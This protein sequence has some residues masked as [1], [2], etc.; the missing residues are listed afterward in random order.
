ML[1]ASLHAD[2]ALRSLLQHAPDQ[3]TVVVGAV[4][5][6]L[7]SALRQAMMD[8]AQSGE[9]AYRSTLLGLR[10]GID[11]VTLLHRLALRE[12]DVALAAWCEE[13]MSLRV[14][15]VADAHASLAWFAENLA[16]ATDTARAHLKRQHLQAA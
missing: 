7:V 5:G 1:A 12:G 15:V 10:H 6:T 2:K 11:V 3:P 9:H 13:W 4:S 8:Y 14:P 16:A